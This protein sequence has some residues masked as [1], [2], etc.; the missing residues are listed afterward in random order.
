[1]EKGR[2]KKISQ[3]ERHAREENDFE[4]L[5]LRLRRTR[6][7]D[8]LRSIDTAIWYA[9]SPVDDGEITNLDVVDDKLDDRNNYEGGL[10]GN[11][12]ARS[13]ETIRLRREARQTKKRPL[14]FPSREEL[15]LANEEKRGAETISAFQLELTRCQTPSSGE[16]NGK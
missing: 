16:V 10:M 4:A 6:S 14:R 11:E 15:K 1:M 5:K 12:L 2:T 3:R 8:S 7:D 9:Q 13:L